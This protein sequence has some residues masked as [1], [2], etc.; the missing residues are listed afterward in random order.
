M[1]DAQPTAGALIEDLRVGQTASIAKTVTAADIDQFASIT[2]DNNPVHLNAAYAAKTRFKARIA[3]GMLGAGFISAVLGT[4][5]PGPGAIYISQSLAFKAPVKI[6]D[7]VVAKAT[8]TEVVVEKKRV[9]M[10]TVCSVGETTVLEG[11]A[12]LLVPSRNG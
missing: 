8:V 4:K 7:T 6:G 5:L 3:H 9:R 2:G 1:N 11:E 10:A 12:M